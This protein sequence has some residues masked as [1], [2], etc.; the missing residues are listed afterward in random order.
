[1]KHL[2]KPLFYWSLFVLFG[3]LIGR[4]AI[5][6]DDV[7]AQTTPESAPIACSAIDVVFLIDQSDSMSG[8]SGATATDPEEQRQYAPQGVI[9]ILTDMVSNQ[10]PDTIHR[11]AVISYGTDA[12][13]DLPLSEIRY[14]TAQEV[15]ENLKDQIQAQALGQTNPKAAF[16][17]AN[18]ILDNAAPIGEGVRKRVIIFITDG[19]PCI[20]D[21]GC[22]TSGTFSFTGYAQEMDEQITQD[23][24][25]SDSL[26]E[27]EACIAT[28]RDE[29]GPDNPLPG[30]AVNN[31]L[32]QYQVS[33]DAYQNSTYIWMILLR[34]GQAYPAD[35]RQI[36]AN[37]AESHAGEIIDLSDNRSEIPT[38]F[39]NILEQLTGVR[40]IR[41]A[42]G[43]FAV[44][45]YLDKAVLTFYKYDANVVVSLSYTD[46]RGTRYEISDGLSDSGFSIADYQRD[47]AN[48]RY[49]LTRPYPGIWNLSSENCDGLD[50]F[51]D[52][53]SFSPEAYQ[54]NIPAEL[55]QRDRTPFYD[56]DSPHYLEYQMLDEAGQ[57]VPQADHP[58]FAINIRF[59]VTDPSGQEKEY[60]MAWVGD[61]LLFRAMEPLQTP[62][63]GGYQIHVTG[64]TL[65][66]EG[67]PSPIDN[68]YADV[69]NSS[70]ELLNHNGGFTVFEVTPFVLDIVEPTAE[71]VLIPVHGPAGPNTPPSLLPIPIRVRI[72]DRQG[73]ALPD[74]NNVFRTPDNVLS[75]NVTAGGN[76]ESILLTRDLATTNEY[77]GEIP[78]LNITGDHQI[79][80]NLV[81]EFNED[82]YPDNR[83]A[84]VAFT[85][86]DEIW[87]FALVSP[88][89]GTEVRPV[90]G[91][92]RDGWPLPVH[93][94]PIRVQL[95]DEAGQPYTNI[96]NI[97]PYAPSVLTTTVTV[98][99][100]TAKTSLLP[101]STIPGQYVGQIEGIGETGEYRLSVALELDY[102]DYFTPQSV[103]TEITFFRIDG[104]WNRASTYY[105]ILILII[106]IIIVNIIRYFAIRTNPITGM[107]TFQDGGEPIATFGLA[108]GKNWSVIKSRKLKPYP[109]LE[110]KKIVAENKAKRKRSR[111]QPVAD[112]SLTSFDFQ[113]NDA[114][115]VRLYLTP[116][117]GPVSRVELLP[118]TPSPF[119]DSI[120]QVVY[121]PPDGSG[122][123]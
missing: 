52:P 82:Y 78:G 35:L 74:L 40:A 50:T 7:Y 87:R 9:D 84:S 21:L 73:Q 56:E 103:P 15:R 116:L 97:I 68:N 119:G 79:V 62:I 86:L 80:V 96:E 11:V 48:E 41:L 85:R 10:C 37:I 44:N 112:P 109:Q 4:F 64:T 118:G 22:G 88:T 51:Y 101:D 3:L 33:D 70:Y 55:P 36:Y 29:V 106:A 115:G 20:R 98:G 19:V 59:V 111:S 43:S 90:H 110:L 113:D 13:L 65:R 117:K 8:N 63:V 104:L 123:I 99:E 66:R 12:T 93:P 23:F 2:L 107:L 18:Q 69:F 67:E 42:C 39:R 72:T 95:V 45:P 121:E 46:V 25:F 6:F 53:I 16:E 24:P 30:E 120:F 58:Q 54:P 83:L 32:D 26:L 28:L 89:D 61:E 77:I 47:G 57:V 114:A 60:P 75:A 94:L 92:L 38:T 49:V 108:S 105:L 71:Q 31:C 14:E 102:P 76:S 17:L 1:M 100:I 34:S 27:R 122:Q 91:T 81:S 5:I